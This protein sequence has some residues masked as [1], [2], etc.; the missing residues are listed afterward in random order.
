MNIEF[1]PNTMNETMS[2][3]SKAYTQ[4]SDILQRKPQAAFLNSK[5]HKRADLRESAEEH[6]VWL[7][8]ARQAWLDEARKA[9]Q[10]LRQRAISAGVEL[11]MHHAWSHQHFIVDLYSINVLASLQL[12]SRLQQARDEVERDGSEDLPAIWVMPMSAPNPNNARLRI[13]QQQRDA[14]QRSR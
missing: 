6:W 11:E 1:I 13:R 5:L 8:T 14:V 7:S 2:E 9:A 10:Q 3:L 4:A 12:L